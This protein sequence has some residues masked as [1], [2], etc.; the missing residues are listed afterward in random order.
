M[1]YTYTGTGAWN[2]I[3]MDWNQ[4]YI[5]PVQP[6]ISNEEYQRQRAEYAKE[7]KARLDALQAERDKAE[8]TACDLLLDL[9]GEEQFAVYKETG[10]L[11]VKGREVDYLITREGGFV[12]RIEKDKVVDL[13]IHLA[14]QSVMPRTDSVIALKLFAEADEYAFNKKANRHGF[15][16]RDRFQIPKAAVA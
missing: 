11:L 1:T 6:Q 15:V 2:V 10:R 8:A 7:Q 12:K 13:C 4:G 3:W 14:E 16:D 9:I 5:T